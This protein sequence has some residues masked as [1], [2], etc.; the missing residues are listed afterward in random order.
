MTILLNK[1]KI[2]GVA[3]QELSQD[4]LALF[5]AV[6]Y[7]SNDQV[8]RRFLFKFHNFFKL[9]KT[10]SIIFT[11]YLESYKDAY[12]FINL[13]KLKTLIISDNNKR[14]FISPYRSILF[15]NFFTFMYDNMNIKIITITPK[16]IKMNELNRLLT[17]M[18]Y[19]YYIASFLYQHYKVIKRCDIKFYFS[20][21]NSYTREITLSSKYL[22]NQSLEMMVAIRDEFEHKWE[23]INLENYYTP[24]EGIFTLL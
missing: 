24:S 20:L 1:I 8:K 18:F 15:F 14:S 17:F 4:N 13:K 16:V 7:K 11:R 23:H 3:T 19:K 22:K 2:I 9:T 21:N 12:F 6:I 5:N 10:I